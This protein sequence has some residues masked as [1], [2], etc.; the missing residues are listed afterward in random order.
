MGCSSSQAAASI[1]YAVAQQ[2]AAQQRAAPNGH[3]SS[4]GGHP[5]FVTAVAPTG[6]SK[7]IGSASLVPSIVTSRLE[8]LPD[9]AP[10]D[11]L[12]ARSIGFNEKYTP[13]KL[14]GRGSFGKVSSCNLSEEYAV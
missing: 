9:D 8:A 1:P 12:S 14:L 2:P 3:A 4:G 5:S 11:L 6:E 13:V 10:S 7:S